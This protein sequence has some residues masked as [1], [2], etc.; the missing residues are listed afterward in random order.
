MGSIL[1]STSPFLIGRFGSIGTSVTCPL[2]RGTIG[3]TKFCARTSLDEG[4]TMFMKR[5]IIASM[6][7]GIV[8]TMTWLVM[9]QGSHFF[10]KKMN[11]TMVE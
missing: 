2:T 7:T 3:M 10:L 11:Q 5:M 8:T 9:F 4:A 6:I 1:K